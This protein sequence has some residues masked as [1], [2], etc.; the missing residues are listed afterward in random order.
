MHEVLTNILFYTVKPKIYRCLRAVL[1][2]RCFLKA[3]EKDKLEATPCHYG[4]L[5]S[6]LLGSL[7]DHVGRASE[8]PVW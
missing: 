2:G 3:R 6:I 4:E 5:E 7:G 8:S 1:G